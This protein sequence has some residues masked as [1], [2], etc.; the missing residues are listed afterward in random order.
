MEEKKKQSEGAVKPIDLEFYRAA[1][2]EAKAFTFP[3]Y[4]P[5]VIDYLND[6]TTSDQ[7]KNVIRGI[8]NNWKILNAIRKIV[9]L[10]EVKP[11]ELISAEEIAA[12]VGLS[13]AS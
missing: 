6:G 3:N 11:G 9:G 1:L 13:K 8:V 10:A 2:K 4:I 5:Q 12:T 7:V